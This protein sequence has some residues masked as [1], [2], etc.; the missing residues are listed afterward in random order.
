MKKCLYLVLSLMMLFAVPMTVSANAEPDSSVKAPKHTQTTSKKS[1]S[2]KTADN[3]MSEMA[4]VLF[5]ISGGVL[6]F[7]KKELDRA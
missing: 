5:A 2:P 1:K 4:L 6:C 7:A 3:G